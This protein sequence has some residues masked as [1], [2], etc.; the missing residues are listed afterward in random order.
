MGVVTSHT[1]ALTGANT[2]LVAKDTMVKGAFIIVPATDAT[3][4]MGSVT[5]E[6]AVD[7]PKVIGAVTT[8][9]ATDTPRFMG[10]V[11]TEKP[12]DIIDPMDT[13]VVLIDD[14]LFSITF[15]YDCG[16]L[17]LTSLANFLIEG[18]NCSV[19]TLR[20]Y[21]TKGKGLASAQLILF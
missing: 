5:N 11:A 12:V 9:L 4:P 16:V 15:D 10:A 18:D 13:I 20:I 21:A 14:S 17:D 19:F 2:K 3:V 6:Y 8:V 1:N 7:T